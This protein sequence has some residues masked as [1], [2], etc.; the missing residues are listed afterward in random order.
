M[1]H[2]NEEWYKFEE[3]LTCRFKID[4]RNV[5][6]YDQ[7]T[8]MTKKFELDLWSIWSFWPNYIMF[9][10]KKYRVVVFHCTEEWCKI[11]RRTDL[12]FQ[13]WQEFGEIWP[14]H[15]KISK[16]FT[17]I[18]SFFAK[19]IMFDLKQ[20]RWVIFKEKQTC[21]LENGMSNLANFYQSTWNF[22]DW[23]SYGIL[24]PK[25]KISELKF[26]RG[27]MYYD[28]EKWCKF[29]EELT[30]HFKIEM[31]NFINFGVS[32]QKSKNIAL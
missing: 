14:R 6:N 9:E 18:G 31:R 12:L 1:S 15:S 30:R 4:M 22:Q 29:E 13:K 20:Y 2:D 11:C 19:Y 7:G 21:G 17:L 28:N 10:L 27:V 32:T 25:Q 5:T 8:R 16:I 26:Y 23:D 3:E 24:C